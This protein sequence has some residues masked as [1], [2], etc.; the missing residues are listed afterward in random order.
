LSAQI[1]QQ[2]TVKTTGIRKGLLCLVRLNSKAAA[3][4]YQQSLAYVL[5]PKSLK[6]LKE[7]GLP[8]ELPF[9]VPLQKAA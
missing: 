7:T 1:G 3:F 8:T 6:L 4:N 5:K 9:A 2:P